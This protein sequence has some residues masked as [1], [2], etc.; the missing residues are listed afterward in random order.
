MAYTISDDC[1]SCGTCMEAC[2]SEAIKEGDPKYAIDAEACVE[3]GACVDA[4]PTEA[5]KEE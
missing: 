4:C 5:I 1:T 2:P 3:C